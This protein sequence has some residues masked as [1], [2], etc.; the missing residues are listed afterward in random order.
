[1]SDPRFDPRLSDPVPR[2]DGTDTNDKWGWIAGVT[3]LALIAIFLIAG[4]H[5]ANQTTA[6]NSAS[7]AI[8]PPANTLIGAPPVRNVTP[9]STTG[10]GAPP[11]SQNDQR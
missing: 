10:F 5:Y 1:M 11:Q 2:Y 7:T 9:R 4:G 8:K 3:I 6:D